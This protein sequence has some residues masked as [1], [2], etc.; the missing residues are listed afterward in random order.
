MEGD[1]DASCI[2]DP[3]YT[4]MVCDE[5]ISD[6]Y[7]N[8]CSGNGNF[9]VFNGS[10]FCECSP[11][12]T[13]MQ[14]ETQQTLCDPNPCANGAICNE[15]NSTVTCVCST[16]WT[17]IYCETQ[18]NTSSVCDENPCANNASCSIGCLSDRNC[19]NKMGQEYTCQ[20]VPGFTGNTCYEDDPTI[21]FCEP[22][23]CANSGTCIEEYGPSVS[24][25]CTQNFRGPSCAEMI[26]SNSDSCSQ[27]S[28]DGQVVIALIC[29]VASVV[30][31]GMVGTFITIVTTVHYHS[32]GKAKKFKVSK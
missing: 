25:L 27:S 22:H 21:T 24:C 2:C 8:E 5:V 18:I 1:T 3:G 9:T 15:N 29:A 17:G 23:S 26:S 10:W 14:C 28:L 13:G 19:L 16:G 4:G 7:F 6:C 20:C 31:V 30:I 12:W 11:G 32:K